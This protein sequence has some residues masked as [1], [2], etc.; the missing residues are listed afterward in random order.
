MGRNALFMDWIRLLNNGILNVIRQTKPYQ[1]YQ[2][3]TFLGQ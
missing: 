2:L 1:K 3:Q